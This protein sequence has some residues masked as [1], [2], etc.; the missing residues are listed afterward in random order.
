MN[1]FDD[2]DYI[3]VYGT[4]RRNSTKSIEQWFPGNAIYV[5]EGVIKG[6]LYLIEDY[7]GLI[8]HDEDEQDEQDSNLRSLN[9]VYGEI[10]RIKNAREL[11]EILDCYE[12]CGP[13]YTTPNEY[14]REKRPVMEKDK[15][16]MTIPCWVYLYNLP[17]DSRFPQINSGDFY[18]AHEAMTSTRL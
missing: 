11:L 10:Y 1:N 4:L 14:R 7:P 9:Q 2:L 8:I 6:T 3:F 16:N 12:E 13:E 18:D 15:P 5:A 17:V